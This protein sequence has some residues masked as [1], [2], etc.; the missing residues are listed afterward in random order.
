MQFPVDLYHPDAKPVKDPRT[1]FP[2][3]KIIHARN[4]IE[5]DGL[6]RIGW[7]VKEQ[8]KTIDGGPARLA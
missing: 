3:Q 8:P 2:V 4:Q 5:L 7:K 6:T 1:G